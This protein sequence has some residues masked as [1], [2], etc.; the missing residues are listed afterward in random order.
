MIVTTVLFKA[1]P[2][3]EIVQTRIEGETLANDLLLLL[4]FSAVVFTM[5]LLSIDPDNWVITKERGH[6][7]VYHSYYIYL[8]GDLFPKN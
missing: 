2:A 4:S 6:Q 3:Y 1:T 5:L 8:P 7:G